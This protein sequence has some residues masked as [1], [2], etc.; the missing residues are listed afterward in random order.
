MWDNK[1]HVKVGLQILTKLKIMQVIQENV[2]FGYQNER[3]V[4]LSF[5]ALEA[6]LRCQMKTKDMLLTLE[7][8]KSYGV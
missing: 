5:M 3:H 1:N 2:S 4:P 8:N 6:V 7:Q